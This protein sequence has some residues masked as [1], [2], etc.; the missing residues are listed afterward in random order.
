MIKIL[1]FLVFVTILHSSESSSIVKKKECSLLS[2]KYFEYSTINTDKLT[3]K[4][5]LIKGFDNFEEL[6]FDCGSVNLTLEGLFFIP[7]K[8]VL[9]DNTMNIKR[10][11]YS[12]TFSYKDSVMFTRIKGFNTKSPHQRSGISYGHLNVLFLSSRFD[13]YINGT[14]IDEKNCKLSYFSEKYEAFGPINILTIDSLNYFSKKTCPYVFMNTRLNRLTLGQISN[15]FIIKNQLEFLEINQTNDFDLNNQDLFY[16][17]IGLAYEDLTPKIINK[18]VFRN[19]EA[20][21]IWGVLNS[22]Q[23]EIFI[24]LSKL[25]FV[26]INVQNFRQLLENRNWWQFINFHIN[27]DLNNLNIVKI[28]L[29]QSILLEIVEKES[30][31]KSGLSFTKAYTFPDEDFCLFRYFPHNRLVYPFIVSGVNIECTCTIIWLIQYSHLYY[32]ADYQHFLVTEY[33]IE[34]DFVYGDE[35]INHTSKICIDKDLNKRIQMS[36]IVELNPLPLN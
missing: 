20:I 5:A 4:T 34:Y 14:K 32:T 29:D 27:V 10:L 11:L 7:N 8:G 9:L 12:I 21:N 35:Y 17:N 13:F 31:L 23:G 26:H 16:L 19:L 2:N 15:S 22:I 24:Y 6:N 18:Y 28:N 33:V 25:R 1:F 3:P 36:L 30:N